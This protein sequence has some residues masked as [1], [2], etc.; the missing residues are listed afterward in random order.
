M[1]G[2]TLPVMKSTSDRIESIIP[3][4]NRCIESDTS[5]SSSWFF[6]FSHLAAVVSFILLYSS[7][8]AVFSRYASPASFSWSSSLSTFCDNRPNTIPARAPCWFSSF[9]TSCMVVFL[10]SMFSMASAAPF[11]PSSVVM[12]NCFTESRICLKMVT[13]WSIAVMPFNFDSV[14]PMAL[15]TANELL[16][17]AGIIRDS[18]VADISTRPPRASIVAPRAA[19]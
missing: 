11:M 10:P 16:R 3:P 7:I 6:N 18:A 2:L 15:A 12:S 19:I 17:M 8:R 9:I 1:A 4:M 13:I 5:I 14:M